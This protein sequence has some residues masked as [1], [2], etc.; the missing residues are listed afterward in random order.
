[1]EKRTVAHVQ[2]PHTH[3]HPHSAMFYRPENS[4]FY[5]PKK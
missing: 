4:Y 5:F 2:R 1:M 3:P